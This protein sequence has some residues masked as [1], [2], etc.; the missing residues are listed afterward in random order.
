MHTH[1]HTQQA[2]HMDATQLTSLQNM[3]RTEVTRLENKL[4]GEIELIR[5]Q[6]Q[7]MQDKLDELIGSIEK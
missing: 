2:L 5:Q 6:V 7:D 4:R 1:T 3:I